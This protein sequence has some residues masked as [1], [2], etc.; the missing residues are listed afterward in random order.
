MSQIISDAVCTFYKAMD[1]K[2]LF[3]QRGSDQVV[4]YYLECNRAP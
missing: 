1:T 2:A 3:V 4:I